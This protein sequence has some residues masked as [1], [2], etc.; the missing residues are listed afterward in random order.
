MMIQEDLKANPAPG[1]ARRSGIDLL[2]DLPWGTHFCQFYQ[3][4]E[5]LL[6]VVLPYLR[7]GL[8][9]NEFCLWI[10]CD[11]LSERSALNAMRDTMPDF[12]RHHAKGQM[13]ILPHSVWYVEDGSFNLR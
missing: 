3:T 6:D 12:Y 1:R 9:G 8:E 4:E 5:E 13:E 7:A 11:P 10:V 2:G